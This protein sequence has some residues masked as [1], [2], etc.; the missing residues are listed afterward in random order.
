MSEHIILPSNASLDIYSDNT[1]SNY[2]TKIPNF[3]EFLKSR[4][5]NLNDPNSEIYV[6]ISELIIPNSYVNIRNNLNKIEIFEKNADDVASFQLIQTINIP[7]LFYN[8]IGKVLNA[9]SKIIDK[10]LQNYIKITY[11][12][13]SKYSTL[14]ITNERFGIKFGH[15]VGNVLGFKSNFLYFGKNNNIKF[16]APYHASIYGG[17]NTLYIYSNII[18]ENLVG[19]TTANL[20]GVINWEH[21]NDRENTYI[22]FNRLNYSKLKRVDVDVIHMQIFDVSGH[23]IE[24]L[25]GT[26]VIT[27]HL[28]KLYKESF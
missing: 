17:V 26:S 1:A 6:A 12:K 9:F 5:G 28:K 11:D 4:F 27:L 19:D 7:P 15:D 13:V 3:R 21:A 18:Q 24:F 25:F 10:Q 23:A 22:Q 14:N 20:L 2:K 8:S 16:K